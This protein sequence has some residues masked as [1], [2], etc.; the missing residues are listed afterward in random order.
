M[1]MAQG[2]KLIKK[3]EC[4]DTSGCGK[5]IITV[6]DR[7]V[8]T[9]RSLKVGNNGN[10]VGQE[11]MLNSVRGV[12]CANARKGN[13]SSGMNGWIV[14]AIVIAIISLLPKLL[15]ALTD[16]LISNADPFD[17]GVPEDVLEIFNTVF[18]VGIAIAAVLLIIGL[19]SN[20]KE[21]DTV[22]YNV[23]LYTNA[24]CSLNAVGIIKVGAKNANSGTE[25]AYTIP[26]SYEVAKEMAET[27]GAL[28]VLAR[29]GGP[30]EPDSF[31]EK[32]FTE[33]ETQ[34]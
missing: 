10:A 12:T 2:E 21:A 28:L 17:P 33:S 26:V 24:T 32:E 34:E 9:E 11:V 18:W 6:T 23:V 31:V 13:E 16:F 19:F 8:A 4:Q 1:R 27:I 25:S 14:G 3:W 5:T 7:R 30:R 22:L 29:Y 20:K 15:L